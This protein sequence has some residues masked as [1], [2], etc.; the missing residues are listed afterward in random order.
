[1][2]FRSERLL[3]EA[4][5]L[6]ELPSTEYNEVQMKLLED[7]Y[8]ELRGAYQEADQEEACTRIRKGM[9]EVAVKMLQFGQLK[10]DAQSN[11][12]NQAPVPN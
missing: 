4:K 5:F 12:E 3:D 2:A 8:K 9:Q 11:T 7:I 1:M 6:L 10:Q